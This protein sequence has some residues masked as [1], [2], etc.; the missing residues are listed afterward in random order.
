MKVI[1]EREL[2]RVCTMIL[3]NDKELR[4]LAVKILKK[5][6]R[7]RLN[8]SAIIALHGIA[9][10]FFATAVVYLTTKFHLGWYWVPMT[11][12]CLLVAFFMLQNI[13]AIGS[14]REKYNEQ[15]RNLKDN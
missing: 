2:V 6:E 10:V 15:I 12:L 14:V 7:V 1:Q 11:L 5:K 13:V 3:S 9:V 4:Q 8:Y